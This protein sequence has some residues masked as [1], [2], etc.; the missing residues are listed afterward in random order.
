MIEAAKP[1]QALCSNPAPVVLKHWDAPLVR[2]RQTDMASIDVEE[3]QD[4]I[5][6][7]ETLGFKLQLTVYKDDSNRFSY[8]SSARRE[9]CVS[10]EAVRR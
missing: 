7:L 3:L 6:T 4:R 5:Q 10:F 8:S 1:K 2:T 9:D